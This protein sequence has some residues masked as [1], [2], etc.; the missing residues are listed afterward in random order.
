MRREEG[1]TVEQQQ[2]PTLA[3][4]TLRDKTGSLHQ[5]SSSANSTSTEWE[6]VKSGSQMQHLFQALQVNE[7]KRNTD[8]QR[9][10]PCA[11]K[12]AF[13]RWWQHLRVLGYVGSGQA[14]NCLGG[15]GGGQP[16]EHSGRYTFFHSV[17]R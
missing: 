5:R 1:A 10:A 8:L 7:V 2:H 3:E 4:E 13:Q 9:A 15:S 14:E 11:I 6:I 12:S 16:D 17:V